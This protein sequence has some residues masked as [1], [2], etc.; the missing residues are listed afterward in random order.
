MQNISTESMRA[1]TLSIGTAPAEEPIMQSE[2][3]D[4]TQ[5]DDLTGIVVGCKRLNVREAPEPGSAI[6]VVI[7][8][9][10][11]VMVEADASTDEFY[12]I[13]TAA[14]IQGFCMK[15]YIALCN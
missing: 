1:E 12:K 3:V 10:S 4:E 6:L 5:K 14:G 13:C 9:Q 15:E 11:E 8:A 7:P 2:P